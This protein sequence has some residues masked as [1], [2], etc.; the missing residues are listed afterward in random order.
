M[1][2]PEPKP[3]CHVTIRATV[4][5]PRSWMLVHDHDGAQSAWILPDGRKVGTRLAFEIQEGV[6]GGYEDL[7]S[8]EAD[9][10]AIEVVAIKERRIERRF[11][12][13]FGPPADQTFVNKI[14]KSS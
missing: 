4:S 10:L 13:R 7:T 8:D 12:R 2:T 6:G 11:D 14:G 3:E 5:V 1:P 9:S